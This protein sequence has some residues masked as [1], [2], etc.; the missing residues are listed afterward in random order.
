MLEV[1]AFDLD[2][3]L[4]PE[5]EYVLSG[6]RS[7]AELVRRRFKVDDFYL[8]LVKTFNGGERKK[9]FDAT[10]ERLGIEYDETLIQDLIRHYRAHFPDIKL[11]DDAVLTLQ[12]LKKKHHLALITDGYLQAQKSKVRALNIE[13]FFEKI[14]YTDQYGKEYWKPSRFPFQMVMEYFS[15]EGNEC[16]YVGDNMEKDFIGPN[17]LG[18]LTV[19]IKRKEGQYYEDVSA[20]DNYSSQVSIDS[21]AN[22][23]EVL[24][25]RSSRHDDQ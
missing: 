11:F 7:V 18:W 25:E 9:T 21:L 3:T 8:E 13:R 17:R 16:A 4:Y 12:R 15:V 22:L 20:N 5:K 6:F 2:D 23:E 1:I 19:Q 24:G 10:L 14:I